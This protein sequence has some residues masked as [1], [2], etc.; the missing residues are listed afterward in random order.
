MIRKHY[1]GFL[2][3]ADAAQR[4]QEISKRRF[5][6]ARIPW[7]VRKSDELMARLVEPHH[8]QTIEQQRKRRGS[9]DGFGQTIGRVLQSQELFA[10]FEGAFN[11][12]AVGVRCQDLAC[13]PIQFGAVEH[14]IG[15]FP[16]QVA[17]QD[18]RQL[19]VS[20]CLVVES[21]DGFDGERGMQSEL[22]EFEPSPRLGWI[23]GPLLHA[24]ETG[25]FLSRRSLA[26]LLLDGGTFVK[27]ALGMNMA[28]EVNVSRQ[29]RENALAS[30]GAVA[31]EDDL[32]VGVP[33]S[34]QLNEFEGQLRSS[35]MI[36]IGLWRLCPVPS[37]P[38]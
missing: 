34:H 21:L 29:M 33:L 9:L 26:S 15:A 22:I 25:P 12:P 20:A 8:D 37:S 13:A 14:L 24:R 38:W 6:L 23:F 5:F 17:H 31:G 16:F 35:A 2:L 10:V 11:R 3:Q 4:G 32:V 27:R 1:A 30:V 18:D 28:D 36:G 7:P 19:A